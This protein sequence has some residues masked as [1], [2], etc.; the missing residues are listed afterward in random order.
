MN[1]VFLIG[2]LTDAPRI[3][4]STKQDG[5][6]FMVATYTL[7]VDR[8]RA[9]EGQQQADFISCKC[10]DSR[11]EF[12]EKYLTKGMKIA[13]SGKIQTG[14]YTNKDG[15]KVYTTDVLVEEHEFCDSKGAQATQPAA[16]PQSSAPDDFMNI[17]DG[18]DEELPFN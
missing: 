13:V 10:F 8:R 3:N 7:A 4:S 11:A 16:A 6:Q 2:R 17:P 12:A 1:K 9:A 15:V 18:I 5:T 14:S